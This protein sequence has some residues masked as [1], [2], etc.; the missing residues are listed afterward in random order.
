MG[1]RGFLG[2]V[3]VPPDRALQGRLTHL[4]GAKLARFAEPVL[5]KR[6]CRGRRGTRRTGSLAMKALVHTPT[7]LAPFPPD[8]SGTSLVIAR[9]TDDSDRPSSRLPRRPHAWSSRPRRPR[10]SLTAR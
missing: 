7:A 1:A 3:R 4:G 2:G 10:C 9:S 8:E 6:R 5:V